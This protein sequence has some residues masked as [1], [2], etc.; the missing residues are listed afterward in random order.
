MWYYLCEK[1]VGKCNGKWRQHQPSKYEGLAFIPEHK[2]KNTT[3]DIK[4]V[5][6]LKLTEAMQRLM[7]QVDHEDTDEESLE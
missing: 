7:E 4:K 6:R 2:R 1:Y 5:R 3:A